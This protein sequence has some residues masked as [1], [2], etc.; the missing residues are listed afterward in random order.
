MELTTDQQNTIK[1]F[2]DFLLT[3]E[4]KFMIIQGHSGSGKSSLI[5]FLVDIAYKYIQ[6][7][8]IICK[9]TTGNVVAPLL[10]ATTNPATAVLNQLTGY[11][12][13][14]IHSIL[15]LT[16]IND[17]QTG[18]KRLIL[19][20]N[21]VPIYNQLIMIDEASMINDELFRFI[22]QQT[23]DCKIL[24]I[25]DKYQLTPVNQTKTVMETLK[26]PTAVMT[27]ILRNRGVIQTVG[28]Q[29]RHTVQSEI[30]KPI[31]IINDKLLSV[32]G[33]EF[34]KQIDKA[35]SFN[36]YTPEKTKIIAWTNHRVQEYNLYIRKLQQL[37]TEF[38]IGETVYT[39][40]PIIRNKYYKS[41]DQAVTI[42]NISKEF[43]NKNKIVGRWIELDKICNAFQASNS[44]AEKNI[45]KQYARKKDWKN[46]FDIKDN[47]LD[48]RL[49]Y[50]CTTYK[51]QGNSYDTVFI[52]LSDIGKCNIPSD[53]A[54]MLYV[55]ITRARHQVYLYGTL[56]EKYGG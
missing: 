17:Y 47:W 11:K 24:L 34:K 10:A 29:Y 46:Y 28:I 4:E 15:G 22:K 27:E 40:K 51:S 44:G 38:S 25:G 36:Q 50:A 42:T 12:A 39:N 9:T 33:I 2:N 13:E 1:I 49:P 26:C 14:T 20:R 35:F 56:P 19:K 32:S 5:K 7:N 48:L 41:I 8:N 54:R 53:V 21:A 52:D 55:S 18:K 31:P 3:P 43:T 23:I 30:F 6:M 37:P 45:L 16:L